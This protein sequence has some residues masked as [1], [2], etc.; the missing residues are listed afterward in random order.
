MIGLGRLPERDSAADDPLRLRR[1]SSPS[2]ASRSLASSASSSGGR[3]E[4]YCA[5]YARM[6]AI[7][8]RQ[9]AGSTDS[10]ARSDSSPRLQSAAVSRSSGSR[11]QPDGRLRRAGVAV[12]AIEHPRE[13]AQVLA[14]A[15]P[16]EFALGVAPEPVDVE[17]LRR[18][19]ELR[20]DCEPVPPVV[21]KVVAAERLHGHRVAA[22]HADL[23]DRRRGGLR[24]DGRADQH[25]VLP[26]ARLI[27]ER[28][29]F[30]PPAAEHERGDRH[31]LRRPR[32]AA[33][34]WDC[35]WRRP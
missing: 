27:D 8:L 12:A 24:G 16:Q 34:S 23:P 10:S 1:R 9:S 22:H 15:R 28:C 32:Y 13:H 18:L 2:A 26:V 35:A 7:S 20:A 19:R 4:P 17:D 21:G 25:A 30:A 29:D 11:Q 33:S 5:R 14:E 6:S 31:A 3:R